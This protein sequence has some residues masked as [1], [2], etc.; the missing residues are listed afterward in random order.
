LS[1]ETSQRLVLENFPQN[2]FQAKFFLRNGTTPSNVFC[3]KCS[4]DICQ[5]RMIDLGED[6]PQYV[7]SSILSKKIKKF[8]DHA[9]DLLPFLKEH[10]NFTEV[11]TDQEL[12]KSVDTIYRFTEP[13]VIN[14]RGG[15]KLEL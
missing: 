2:K 10:T 12:E 4:K 1:G 8:H 9:A 3:L 6:H 11:V 15:S 7:C 14:I 5:E 13:C